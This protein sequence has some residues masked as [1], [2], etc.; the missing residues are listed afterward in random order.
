MVAP[1]QKFISH[2]LEVAAIVYA[3]DAALVVPQ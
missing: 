1:A 3:F 2:E